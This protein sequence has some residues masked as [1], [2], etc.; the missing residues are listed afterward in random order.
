MSKQQPS[1][2]LPT[3]GFVRI[4]LLAQCLGISRATI[5][6][7]VKEGTF[8]KPVRLGANSIAFKVEEIRQWMNDLERAA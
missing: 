3:E 5:Y 7:K 2:T 6:R 4:Y 8:P 1:T